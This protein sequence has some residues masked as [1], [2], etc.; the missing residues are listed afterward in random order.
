MLFRLLYHLLNGLLQEDLRSSVETYSRSRKKF[1]KP[2][3]NHA[4]SLRVQKRALILHDV[5]LSPTFLTLLR[6]LGV[7]VYD[8]LLLIL[9]ILNLR[10]FSKFLV[11]VL[12]MQSIGA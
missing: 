2:P 9:Q 1:R 8:W 5:I 7:L 6:F 3:V 11:L 12:G 4:K 10:D